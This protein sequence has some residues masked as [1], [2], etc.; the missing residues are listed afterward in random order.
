MKNVPGGD[1][2]ALRTR[3]KAAEL[4][5]ERIEQAMLFSYADEQW[6]RGGEA[7]LPAAL[8]ANLETYLRAQGYRGPGGEDLPLRSLCTAVLA[9]P[10][11]S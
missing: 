4:E 7:A 6:P 11:Q 10:A 8:L 9:L 1:I 2:A 3:V 5:A